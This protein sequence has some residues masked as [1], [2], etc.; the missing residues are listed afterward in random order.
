MAVPGFPQL[1]P[2]LDPNR[3][4]STMTPGDVLQIKV[5]MNTDKG[6]QL[7][8][9]FPAV[10][11]AARIKSQRMGP[12]NINGFV[13]PGQQPANNILLPWP[14]SDQGPTR[15]QV[16]ESQKKKLPE[17]FNVPVNEVGPAGLYRRYR[18]KSM[19]DRGALDKMRREDRG[20]GGDTGQNGTALQQDMGS[21]QQA[22]QSASMARAL[23]SSP[24][25]QRLIQML[26]RGAQGGVARR[27]YAGIP[28][29]PGQTMGLTSAFGAEHRTP[30]RG[31]ALIAHNINIPPGGGP[32][33]FRPGSRGHA[34]V[35]HNIKMA[36]GAQATF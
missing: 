17:G 28:A 33:T 6:Q 24:L 34:L 31:H 19:M 29:P 10:V 12:P 13:F 14:D 15:P 20:N 21:N 5:L 8:Q 35:G 36:P 27:P 16:P 7:Q 25:L 1:S 11:S 18:I 30:D 22:I 3:P 2:Q 23:R 26:S 4:M 9:R 32:A